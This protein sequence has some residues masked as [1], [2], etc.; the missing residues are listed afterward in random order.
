MSKSFFLIA[1]F[2]L[3]SLVIILSLTN[4]EFNIDKFKPFLKILDGWEEIN[5]YILT[6]SF[7][8]IYFFTVIFFLPFCGILSILGGVIFGWLSFFLSILASLF[9]SWIIFQF[10]NLKIIKLLKKDHIIQF[11]NFKKNYFNT[12]ET[13]WL[14]FLRLFPVIPFSVVSIIASQFMTNKKKFLAATFLGS[15]PGLFLHTLVGIKLNQLIKIN[16]FNNIEINTNFSVFAPL[17]ILCFLTL[18]TIYFKH[19]FHSTQK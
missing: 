9:G 6:I 13:L 4:N 3:F 7:F 17:I 10:F 11:N 14:I 8:L 19:N 15:A 18:V 2:F 16:E 1:C 5:F 12:S